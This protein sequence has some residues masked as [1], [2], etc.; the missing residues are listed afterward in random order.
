MKN[1][2]YLVGEVGWEL[3]L[4]K[5]VEQVKDSDKS[6]PLNIHV[7]SPGGSVYD[8]LAIYNYLK[9]LDQEVNTISA[10]LVASIASIIFLAGNKDTRKIHKT[11]SF[12]I[13]LPAGM[14]FGGADEVEKTAEELRKIEDQLSVIY[15]K[16]TDITKER[17]IE[18]M[19]LDEMMD[20]DELKEMGFVNEI[21]EF[22]AVANFNKNNNN[23]MD[24]LTKKE[25]KGMFAKFEEK[26]KNLF[27]K[28]DPTN[29]IVQNANGDDLDFT[30][31]EASDEIKVGDVAEIDGE[32]VTGDQVMPNGDTWKFTD[33][34]LTEIVE[35]DGE[36]DDDEALK[37]KI[38]E[39]ENE[40][41]ALEA[42]N[43]ALQASVDEKETQAKELQKD[44]K[45]LKKTITSR[46]DHKSKS[47]GKKES[48][49]NK[50]GVTRTPLNIKEEQNN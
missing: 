4:D 13:H 3:T 27:G 33:G 44:F 23:N 18:L 2:I 9:G 38:T 34:A 8:G 15:E 35:D 50:D 28:Q 12:L 43:T 20:V 25:A 48:F 19:K 29:K 6:E 41:E 17:A 36:G 21:I 24:A 40:K 46:L 16:E 14:A 10:G 22:K 47:N 31:V 26:M 49:K 37:A 5:V 11:D 1:D 39:L 30:E 42:T 32:N 7:H 45:A